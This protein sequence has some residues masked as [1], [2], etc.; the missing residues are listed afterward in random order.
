MCLNTMAGTVVSGGIVGFEL[1]IVVTY[2]YK[3]F[4]SK[5]SSA[6]WFVDLPDLSD[7]IGPEKYLFF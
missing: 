6:I 1:L 5:S 7:Q 3:I 2:F 4:V